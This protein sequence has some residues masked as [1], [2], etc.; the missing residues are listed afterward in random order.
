[1]FFNLLGYVFKLKFMFDNIKFDV[2]VLI[3]G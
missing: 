3:C 1:M 2:F